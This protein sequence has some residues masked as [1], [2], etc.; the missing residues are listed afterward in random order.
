MGDRRSIRA[1]LRLSLT[2]QHTAVRFARAPQLGAQFLASGNTAVVLPKFDPLMF[3]QAIQQYRV[4][5]VVTNTN[6]AS[7]PAFDDADGAANQ[8]L[9]REASRR[10]QLRSVFRQGAFSPSLPFS[11]SRVV[12]AIA[13]VHRR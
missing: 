13:R 6:L 8:S 9:P 3:L 4:S 1:L 10:R 11:L 12:E 5:C 7:L 2:L